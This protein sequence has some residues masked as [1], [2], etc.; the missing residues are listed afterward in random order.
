[1]SKV[2]FD[3]SR[4]MNLKEWILLIVLSVLWGG[5]FFFNG[6][7]LKEIPV[8]TV[9]FGRVCIAAI[10]LLIFL[11]IRGIPLPKSPSI[12]LALLFMGFINNVVPF[13]L[14][15]AGQ[16]QIGSGLA[17]ILN[18]T[19]PLFTAV[20]IHLFTSDL[21]ERLTP[22]RIMG[23]AFGIVGVAVMVGP[24]ISAIGLTGPEVLGQLAVL[25][26][27][28][29]YGIA[30]VFGRRF[31]KA[32]ISPMVIAA[33]QMTGASIL[34]FPAVIAIDNPLEFI[35]SISMTSIAAVVALALLS[36]AVAYILY[37]KILS[38]AGATNASLVTL[39]VPVSATIL[40]ILF[41]DETLDSGAIAGMSFVGAGLL[42]MDGRI[43][44]LFKQD[45]PGELPG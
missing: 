34:L 30:L 16:T 25:G 21:S 37:F 26:A 9:V 2:K 44:N 39:L 31:A 11:K 10:A 20:I 28:T 18:A 35:G 27:A 29:S 40:G 6:V 33:G 5:S 42:V 19:T 17:A 38:S 15:V 32:G 22:R 23:I 12:L 13:S 24:D 4:T 45:Q 43:L 14:I 7:A 8:F 41:L 3:A 36:T 1:M